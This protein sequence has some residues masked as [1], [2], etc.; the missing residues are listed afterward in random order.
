MFTINESLIELCK[1]AGA[2]PCYSCSE[3]LPGCF[4]S[5]LPKSWNQGSKILSVAKACENKWSMDWLSV[6][7]TDN[8]AAKQLSIA[9][10]EAT[11]EDVSD[12]ERKDFLP[13][14]HDGKFVIEVVPL[15]RGNIHGSIQGMTAPHPW[16]LKPTS[17]QEC[18]SSK[19]HADDIMAVVKLISALYEPAILPGHDKALSYRHTHELPLVARHPG[20]P[21]LLN[22]VITPSHSAVLLVFEHVECTLRDLV[23]FSADTVKKNQH[24]ALFLVYQILRE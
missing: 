4:V 22:A 1:E 6:S 13:L 2:E 11:G 9:T 24:K 16:H 10:L 12:T 7:Q 8:E 15:G 20:F 5:S 19:Q 3:V 21:R 17:A 23:R 18:E 14:M